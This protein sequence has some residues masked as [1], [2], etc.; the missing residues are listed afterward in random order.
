MLSAYVCQE[1]SDD[2]A[3]AL[4]EHVKQ[5]EVCRLR[6]LKMEMF[7]QESDYFLEQGFQAALDEVRQSALAPPETEALP[8]VVAQY[9]W[10]LEE[11]GRALTGKTASVTREHYFAT[12]K[13][14][15]K[16]TCAWGDALDD[17]PAFLWL[18]W[19][20]D[21]APDQAFSLQLVDVESRELFF[22][23]SPVVT[24]SEEQRT[25]KEDELRFNPVRERWGIQLTIFGEA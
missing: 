13:G 17:E 2:S 6:S 16:I 19:E 21:F 12:Q 5:C 25:F 23:I 11:S 3:Q 4:N 8:A 22:T 9:L 20:S 24:A 10:E 15:L 7:R 1:L 18:S 14:C